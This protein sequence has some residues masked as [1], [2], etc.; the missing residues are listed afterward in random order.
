MAAITVCTAVLALHAFAPVQAQEGEHVEFSS[1]SL[2]LYA[3]GFEPAELTLP[4]G[5]VR[6]KVYNRSGRRELDLVL[7]REEDEQG[8]KTM[9]RSERVERG[10]RKWADEIR[11]LTPGVYVLR[12]ASSEELECRVTVVASGQYQRVVPTGR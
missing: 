3:H 6:L 11:V 7:E 8:P 1:A 10:N 5:P 9:L 4:A 2:M 12:E